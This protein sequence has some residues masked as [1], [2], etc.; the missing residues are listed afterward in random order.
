[1]VAAASCALDILMEQPELVE[2]LA[3]NADGLRRDLH[4]LSVPVAGR[5]GPILRVPI[6]DDAKCIRLASDLLHRGIYV[7]S[8]LYPSV[9]R[10]EAMIRLCVSARHDPAELHRAAEEFGDAYRSIIG[11]EPWL[12][13]V[14]DDQPV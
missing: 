12:R 1:M 6:N 8:V 14:R 2:R 9:P 4:N 11:S 13:Q 5:Q 7:N 3:R 10:S